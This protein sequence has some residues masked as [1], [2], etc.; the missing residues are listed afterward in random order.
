MKRYRKVLVLA[1]FVLSTILLACVERGLTS[2]LSTQQLATRWSEEEP[3]AQLA[4]YFTGETG[5][6]VDQIQSV[7]RKLV[8]AMEEASITSTNENG[9]RNWIDAYSSQGE[10]TIASNRASASVR[11]FGVGGDFFQFH[12]LTL[13]S[14]NYFDATDENTDGVILDEVVAWQLFG[15]NDVAGMEIEINGAVY[16][17]RGVVRSDTGLF[18]EAVKEEAAT[19]YVSYDIL[20][21]QYG[22]ELSVDCYEVLVANPVDEFGKA[23][24]NNA[25]GMEEDDYELIECSARFDLLHRIDVIKNFGIRSM[26]TQNIVFPYW[27]NRARGY[28]DISA[29][30][31]VLEVVCMVYPVFFLLQSAYRLWKKRKALKQKLIEKCKE[32]WKFG[33]PLLKN[34]I[35]TYKLVNKRK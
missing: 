5:F 20:A 4:C 8:T 26:T 35:K 7:E 31:L 13:L 19:I 21:G 3:F 28:E 34:T 17:V 32:L 33:Y 2:S 16:P 30:F 11:A 15:S 12:P 25:L 9:G 24:L 29:L 22:G 18:S 14:G 6:S 1:A 23:T 27:E 10:L